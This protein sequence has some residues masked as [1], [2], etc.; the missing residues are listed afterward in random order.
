MWIDKYDIFYGISGQTKERIM[1]WT[2][3]F[4]FSIILLFWLQEKSSI[5][6]FG[7]PT[8]QKS[9]I[10]LLISIFLLGLVM[11]ILI[12]LVAVLADVK[13]FKKKQKKYFIRTRVLS[14]LQKERALKKIQM[15]KDLYSIIIQ[16]DGVKYSAL[17][18]NKMNYYVKKL[19]TR[20]E[21][22]SKTMFLNLMGRKIKEELSLKDKEIDYLN[23]LLF[24]N[25]DI[26]IFQRL[27]NDMKK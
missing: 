11:Y 12:L 7:L 8:D 24:S 27:K 9:T 10:L 5:L 19:G 17:T 21:I 14:N 22:L 20:N 6:Y 26:E 2:F 3:S 13:Q 4:I 1:Y 15:R 25:E 16:P 18:E 23:D